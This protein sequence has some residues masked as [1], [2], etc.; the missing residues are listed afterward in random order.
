M[1]IRDFSAELHAARGN[2]TSLCLLVLD[3]QGQG[4]L[5]SET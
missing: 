3:G 5:E 4:A 1:L 2:V